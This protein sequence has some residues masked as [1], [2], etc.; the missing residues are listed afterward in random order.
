[1][2]ERE[3]RRKGE[4]EGEKAKEEKVVAWKQCCLWL[5]SI[6]QTQSG[7]PRLGGTK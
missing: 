6:D 5:G 1:M 3:G 4:K 7:K 2:L